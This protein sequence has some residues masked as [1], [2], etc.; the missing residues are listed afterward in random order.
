MKKIITS[1]L[2]LSATLLCSCGIRPLPSTTSTASADSSAPDESETVT[3]AVTEPPVTYVVQISPRFEFAEKELIPKTYEY[4]SYD[5]AVKKAN[6]SKLAAEG[7]AVYTSDGEFV[8]SKYNEFVS[9]LLAASK[10]ITDYIKDAGYTY[11][12]AAKNPAITYYKRI[13]SKRGSSGEKI[14]SCDRFVGW[15]LYDVGF[16][17][18]PEDGG[19]YVYGN[20]NN[21]DH[22]L[23]L[24]LEK[25]GWTRIEDSTD[26]QAGDIIF[27]RK[28]YAN[29]E[30]YGAHVFICAGKTND[31]RSSYYRYDCGSN[32]RVNC[33]GG[34]ASYRSGQ[35]FKEG[36]SDFAYSYRFNPE[37]DTVFKD[38][39][40]GN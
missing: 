7:Y 23:G 27:V 36:I 30:M 2:L 14:V 40:A 8:Y 6:D 24:F 33:T 28:A 19:M 18:Q 15:A 16:T 4:A 25:Y 38:W 39:L 26:I 35:P 12:S 1:F 34:Y 20:S 17:D 3:D 11:G 32:D 31:G 13:E 9:A 5:E 10:H 22:H 21:R 29:G 37:T